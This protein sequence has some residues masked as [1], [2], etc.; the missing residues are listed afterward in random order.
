MSNRTSD[1]DISDIACRSSVWNETLEKAKEN[2]G[3]MDI[4]F[5]TLHIGRS[6]VLAPEYL[7]K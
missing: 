4:L 5:N 7:V 6:T 1:G 2:L 3:R